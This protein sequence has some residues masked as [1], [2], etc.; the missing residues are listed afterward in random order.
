MKI[1]A[2]VI[3]VITAFASFATA[4]EQTNNTDT[5]D[6]VIVGGG[7]GGKNKKIQS[8]LENLVLIFILFQGLALASRLSENKNVTVAVLEAGP[9]AGDQFVVYAPGM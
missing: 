8:M 5:Y 2:A 9:Y 6:Y 3:T 1:S 4:Q 7:V